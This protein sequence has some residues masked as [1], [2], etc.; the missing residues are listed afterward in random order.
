MF[1]KRSVQDLVTFVRSKMSLS[2]K[3]WELLEAKLSNRVIRHGNVVDVPVLSEGVE[4]EE[5]EVI[6]I[7]ERMMILN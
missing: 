1:L 4:Y 6:R 2:D 3:L 5:E 7:L